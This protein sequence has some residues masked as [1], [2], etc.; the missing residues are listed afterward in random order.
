MSFYP[1]A[2]QTRLEEQ[3]EGRPEEAESATVGQGDE[4]GGRAD[5]DGEPG[6]DE[7]GTRGAG[8]AESAA[9]GRGRGG[10]RTATAASPTTTATAAAAGGCSKD[11]GR[12]V[13][14][15]GYGGQMTSAFKKAVSLN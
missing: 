6:A 5:P 14:S 10:P 7:E 15:Y 11:A 13:S 4:G 2:I 3:S 8:E 1:R 9:A 12:Q